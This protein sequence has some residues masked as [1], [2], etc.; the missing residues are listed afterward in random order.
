MSSNKVSFYERG[1][2][3]PGKCL[4]K[5]TSALK[6][7][8]EVRGGVRREKG[9]QWK[10]SSG[11]VHFRSDWSKLNCSSESITDA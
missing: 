9:G 4:W 1:S 6:S 2:K 8:S 7:K 3:F 5:K 11:H 10:P